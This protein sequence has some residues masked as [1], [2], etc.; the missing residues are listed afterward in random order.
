M[1][2]VQSG[3]LTGDE[4]YETSG[5]LAMA[6]LTAHMGKADLGDVGR[7][8]RES[9]R[10]HGA[11]ENQL[12]AIVQLTDG[13]TNPTKVVGEVVTEAWALLMK[14]SIWSARYISMEAATADL[15]NPSLKAI[16]DLAFTSSPTSHQWSR[17]TMRPSVRDDE[18][19]VYQHR[20]RMNFILHPLDVNIAQL[21]LTELAG[22]GAWN[23]WEEEGDLTVPDMFSWLWDGD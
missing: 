22:T 16:R 23:D 18:L 2:I 7:C 13:A 5:H 12:K 11:K 17:M 9:S 15:D 14:G 10:S 20:S 3:T 6:K 1:D 19:V 4:R 8:T 21:I